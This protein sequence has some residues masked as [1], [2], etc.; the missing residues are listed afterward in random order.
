MSVVD[1]DSPEES[2][3]RGLLVTVRLQCQLEL[4]RLTE[5]V[6]PLQ[7]RLVRSIQFVTDLVI[8]RF[9]ARDRRAPSPANSLS[10]ACADGHIPIGEEYQILSTYRKRE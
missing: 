1:F 6:Q 3:W 4:I 5:G 8:L 9:G 10:A 2:L 7:G